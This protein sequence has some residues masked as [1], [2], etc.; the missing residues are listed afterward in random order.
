[1]LPARVALAVL[2]CLSLAGCGGV[3]AGG[4]GGAADTPYAPPEDTDVLPYPPGADGTGVEDPNALATAHD[5]RLEQRGVR[6]RERVVVENLTGDTVH[7]TREVEVWVG[8]SRGTYRADAELRGA[9]RPVA[10]ASDRRTNRYDVW[11]EDDTVYRFR[12]VGFE[13]YYERVLGEDERPVGTTAF[14]EYAAAPDPAVPELVVRAF[15]GVEI[16]GV[17]EVETDDVLE[18]YRYEGE[19]V[20]NPDLLRYRRGQQVANASLSAVVDERGMIHSL[21]LRY[22]LVEGNTTLAVRHQYE[23]VNRGRVA[24]PEP[25]WVVRAR[26]NER[27]VVVPRDESVPWREGRPLAI[28][29]SSGD[30]QP[31]PQ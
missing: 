31:C 18:H 7:A 24:P 17:T 28:C 29:R 2:L 3:F 23:V 27:D 4:E 16:T 1:M 15:A 20:E 5:D 22:E 19:G 11:G 13:T 12:K 25:G 10:N 6:T 26:G 30:A 14:L 9:R 8:S 21:T